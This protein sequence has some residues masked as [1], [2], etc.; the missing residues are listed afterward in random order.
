[1]RNPKD[2]EMLLK[3]CRAG[4]ADAWSCIVDQYQSLVYSVA[5][6]H[7]LNADDAADVFQQTFQTLHSNL[8]RIRVDA[9]VPR[10]LAV[11]AARESLKILRIRKRT[12][13]TEDSTLEEI[14]ATEER[15]AEQS[16]LESW[17][18]VS[19]REAVA[20]LKDRC[21]DLLTL[22]YF[23]DLP[24]EEIGARTGMPMGAIGPTRARCLE[25]V[26]KILEGQGFFE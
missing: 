24:Y 3:R 2:I 23:E 1:M 25:K 5:I 4:D 22:L 20:S 21:R 8:E 14:V 11:T 13:D 17:Q 12:V 16:A 6:K 15:S 7:G 19:L 10:W 18:S 9:T 26:R